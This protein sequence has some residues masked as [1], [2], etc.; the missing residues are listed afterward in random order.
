MDSGESRNPFC[1]EEEATFRRRCIRSNKR[2]SAN[3]PSSTVTT[4]AKYISGAFLYIHT[5]IHVCLAYG[6]ICS[7][8]NALTCADRSCPRVSVK[9]GGT[10]CS[11][12]TAT[13][14]SSYIHTTY[15]HT[16]IHTHTSLQP[17]SISISVSV[18]IFHLFISQLTSPETGWE[19]I[20]YCNIVMANA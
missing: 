14:E 15:I 1:W 20:I 16:Y 18:F 8:F 12:D 17:V 11:V 7:N 13:G 2:P 9:A 10:R 6:C 5:Y 3:A 19:C 4:L